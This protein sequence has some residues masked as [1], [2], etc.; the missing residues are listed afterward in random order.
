VSDAVTLSLAARPD[1]VLV[2]DCIA[3]DRFAGLDAK[4][5]AELPVVHGGRPGTLGEFFRVRGGHSSVVRG[6]RH[7]FHA[8]RYLLLAACIVDETHCRGE[9]VIS[10]GTLFVAANKAQDGRCGRGVSVV[11][12]CSCAMVAPSEKWA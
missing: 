11:S 8:S 7:S 6:C 5:I 9:F 12:H 4:E 3:A 2:A 10:A 1:H